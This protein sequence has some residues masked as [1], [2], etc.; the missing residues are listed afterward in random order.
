MSIPEHCV[1]L[2]V[3]YMDNPHLIHVLWQ[4]GTHETRCRSYLHQFS[5]RAHHIRMVGRSQKCWENDWR[6]RST[7][8]G[9][10]NGYEPCHPLEQAEWPL[11]MIATQKWRVTEDRHINSSPLSLALHFSLASEYKYTSLDFLT[12]VDSRSVVIWLCCSGVVKYWK[13]LVR[14]RTYWQKRRQYCEDRLRAEKFEQRILLNH[15]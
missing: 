7:K 13:V 9:N 6:P 10:E 12:S 4:W 15:R 14:R 3:I 2:T 11:R 1:A 8:R 5:T